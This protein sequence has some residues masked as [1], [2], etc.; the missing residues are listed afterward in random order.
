LQKPQLAK[1][2]KNSLRTKEMKEEPEKEFQREK[3]PKNQ[4]DNSNEMN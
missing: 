2:D 4:Q 3:S 1:K